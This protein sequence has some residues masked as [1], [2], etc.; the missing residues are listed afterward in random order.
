MASGKS[1]FKGRAAEIMAKSMSKHLEDFLTSVNSSDHLL[2]E[3]PERRKEINK[4]K[5]KS[6]PE[7]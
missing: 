3:K 1:H 2:S 5:K 7:F 6:F 4:R